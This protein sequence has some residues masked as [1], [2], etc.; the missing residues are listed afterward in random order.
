[1]TPHAA[2]GDARRASTPPANATS[3]HGKAR[4]SPNRAS[5]QTAACSACRTSGS[6]GAYTSGPCSPRRA[7]T[8]AASASRAGSAPVRDVRRLDGQLA[9]A[10]AEWRATGSGPV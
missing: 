6:E 3:R 8:Y 5:A 10:R 7:V 4:T 2:A 1:M 9:V